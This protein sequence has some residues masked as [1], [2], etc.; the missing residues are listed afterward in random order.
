[1]C[2]ELNVYIA[3]ALIVFLELVLPTVL[4]FALKNHQKALKIC[5]IILA[6][7]FFAFLF[8]GTSAE[9]T[10]EN[11]IV[12][13]HYKFDGN[14]FNFKFGFGST[15]FINVLVNIFLLFPIGYIVFAFSEK[16]NF[17]KCV[18]WAL[19]I[20]LVIETYQWVLPVP[21]GTEIIDLLLNTASGAVAYLYCKLLSVLGGF[22]SKK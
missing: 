19:A 13:A 16:H 8:I 12:S 1:M 21:R 18:L 9:V 4:C 20:S 5:T 15:G 22:K 11:K 6:V 7:I 14:W 2:M 10:L 17:L 3:I